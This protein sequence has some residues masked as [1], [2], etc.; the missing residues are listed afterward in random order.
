AFTIDGRAS[1]Q[2][3]PQIDPH[4]IGIRSGH[5]YALRLIEDLGL[6]PQNGVVLGSMVHYN[7][8]AEC[9]RLI[10]LFDDLF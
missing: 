10:Q 8:L 4:K 1:D 9:D 6:L 3:P 2:I 7:T 5:F